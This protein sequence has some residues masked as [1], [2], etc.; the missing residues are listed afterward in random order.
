MN[1][2]K[3]D[4]RAFECYDKWEEFLNEHF[5]TLDGKIFDHIFWVT[6]FIINP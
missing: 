5:Y 6:K 4:W 2:L 3:Y 1:I